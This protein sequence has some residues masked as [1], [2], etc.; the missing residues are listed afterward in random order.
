MTEICFVSVI[1]LALLRISGLSDIGWI[2]ILSPL[3]ARELIW[4]LRHIVM[5]I[6][7]EKRH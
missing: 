6:I 3:W 4:M 2:W 5:I 1:V 7:E